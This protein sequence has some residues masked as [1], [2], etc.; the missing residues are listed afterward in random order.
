MAVLLP[1]KTLSTSLLHALRRKASCHIQSMSWFW[2]AGMKT[3]HGRLRSG[4]PSTS[5]FPPLKVNAGRVG[6]ACFLCQ[7]QC[8]YVIYSPNQGHDAASFSDASIAAGHPAAD[9]RSTIDEVHSLFHFAFCRLSKV[10]AFWKITI[11]NK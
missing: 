7:L 11:Y 10:P 3:S 4:T 8:L 9:K 1:L 2:P 6:Q 5:D